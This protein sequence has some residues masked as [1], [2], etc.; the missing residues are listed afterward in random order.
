MAQVNLTQ[1]AKLAGISRSTLN[2]HI[3]E[4]RL[5]KG[6]GPDGKPCVETSELQRVYEALSHAKTPRDAP[7]TQHGTAIETAEIKVLQVELEATKERLDEMR[8][9]RD[10]WKGQARTLTTLLSDQRAVHPPQKRRW[11]SVF[12]SPSERSISS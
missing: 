3:K 10:E 1:G 9:D 11:W 12:G 4:G 8:Q 6:I 7:V 5:S 2:R